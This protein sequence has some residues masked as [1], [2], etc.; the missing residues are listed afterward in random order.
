[1][2]FEDP[3]PAKTCEELVAAI[4]PGVTEALQAVSGDI[5]QG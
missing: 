5:E 3:P 1:V 4:P 2:W